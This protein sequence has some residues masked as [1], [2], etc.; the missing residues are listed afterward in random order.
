MPSASIVV[1]ARR[2][3]PS[4]ALAILLCC[5]IAGAGELS[6]RLATEDPRALAAAVA[7]IERA[8]ATT[9]DLADLLYT[10]GRACEDKL[11]DP[12]R[13]LA[14]YDRLLREQPDTKAALGA[15]HRAAHLRTLTGDGH[16]AQAQAFARL[17]AE[18]DRLS[19]PELVTRGEALATAAWPGAAEATLWLADWLRGHGRF[20]EAD[21]H[22]ATLLATWPHAPEARL[23][24]SGQAGAAIEEHALERATRLI[25]A[26][27]A[28]TDE[29]RAVQADLRRSLARAVLR[30]HLDLVA[31]IALVL[32]LGLLLGS[33]IEAAARGG[34][35]R[36]P[37]RPPFEIWFLGPI[38]L[39]LVIA[40]FTAN[41]AIAPAVLRIAIAGVVLAW[42]SGATLDLLRARGR[43]F[44]L[45]SLAHI[46]LCALGVVAIAY[47]AI[48]SSGLFD[49]LAE[50]FKNGPE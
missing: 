10:A 13:A 12:A 41:Q 46:A 4:S 38:S 31:R 17:V 24:A 26:L 8:P 40:S 2:T 25:A 44:R 29:E 14:L 16:A 43:A 34:W 37:L 15:E 45:R 35:R 33:L 32:V 19:Q 27:P 47:L 1:R 22:F 6:N 18:A 50:T 23:A 30:E 21:A 49:L 11:A 20:R 48:S 36:P 7:E 39:V 5:A 3:I 28:T 9:P 42:L